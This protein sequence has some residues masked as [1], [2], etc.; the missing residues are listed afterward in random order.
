VTSAA[1][2]STS[3]SVPE[4]VVAGSDGP[5]VNVAGQVLINP[6]RADWV[7]KEESFW[8]VLAAE[9]GHQAVAGAT[10]MVAGTTP[11]LLPPPRALSAHQWRAAGL[12]QILAQA[13]YLGTLKTSGAATGPGAGPMAL[14]VPDDVRLLAANLTQRFTE[15]FTRLVQGFYV[16]FLGRAATAGEQSGWVG[17]LLSGQTEEQVLSAF[18]STAEFYQRTWTLESAGTGD[19]RFIQ[20]LHR[21]LL[22]RPADAEELGGW[23]GALPQLGRGGVISALLASTEYRSRQ[24]E[25]TYQDVLQRPASSQEIASWVQS[26]FDLKT[27]R[28]LLGGMRDEG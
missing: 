12:G 3:T 11:A 8:S 28:M 4:V 27:I 13:I 7:E 5:S 17:M 26:P 16:Y 18:L 20:G 23:L 14:Q 9:A 6:G 2:D 1:S 24:V 10:G 15:A 19:E 22:G 25:A 21:L